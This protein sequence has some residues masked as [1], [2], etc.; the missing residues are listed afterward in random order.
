ML[1][2]ER[3]FESEKQEGNNKILLVV[4]TT[5]ALGGNSLFSQAE[6]KFILLFILTSLDED[7]DEDDVLKLQQ[8]LFQKL[9]KMQE[10][11][12]TKIITVVGAVSRPATR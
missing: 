3:D 4:D 6:Q 5:N 11:L 12:S 2:G 8:N 1:I 10:K 9:N 7:E